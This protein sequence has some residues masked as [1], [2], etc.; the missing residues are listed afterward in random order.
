[1]VQEVVRE[2]SL[3]YVDLDLLSDGESMQLE[4]S[5]SADLSQDEKKAGRKRHYERGPCTSLI[6]PHGGRT[7]MQMKVR[8]P[9]H[10]AMQIYLR[11][12]GR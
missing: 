3:L 12:R 11:R 10:D 8:R 7:I 9:K 5:Y 1:M 2:G 4:A 6:W